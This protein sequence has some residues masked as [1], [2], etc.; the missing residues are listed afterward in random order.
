MFAVSKKQLE[1]WIVLMD[2]ARIHKTERKI[3]FIEEHGMMEFT[4]PLYST[5]L[6]KIENIFWRI[7]K[8]FKNLNSKELRGIIIEE[9][10]NLS[11]IKF[12]NVFIFCY[13]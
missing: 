6:N 9:I 4:F 11:W 13:N 12:K 2:N 8:S 7:I 5:E 10:K 3:N 1:I